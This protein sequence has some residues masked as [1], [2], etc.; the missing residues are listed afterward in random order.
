MNF[1]HNVDAADMY[2][3]SRYKTALIPAQSI[4]FVNILKFFGLTSCNT[5]K[6][7]PSSSDRFDAGAMIQDL[8]KGKSVHKKKF[9]KTCF[10]VSSNLNPEY[11]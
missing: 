11:V 7:L 1:N 10:K 3:K 6:S 9:Y 4:V 5:P 2:I 8:F